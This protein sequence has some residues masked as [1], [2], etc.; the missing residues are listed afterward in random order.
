MMGG[1]ALGSDMLRDKT[2]RQ[3]GGRQGSKVPGTRRSTGGGNGSRG[4]QRSKPYSVLL[5]GN[6]KQIWWERRKTRW[7]KTRRWD[8]MMGDMEL[9]PMKW[10]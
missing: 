8:K 6:I 9:Q 4:F 5:L 7:S 1:K 10:R 3:S 2:V